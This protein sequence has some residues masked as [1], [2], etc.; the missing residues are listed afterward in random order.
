MWFYFCTYNTVAV[1]ILLNT[2]MMLN[3]D[4]LS[5]DCAISLVGKVKVKLSH[6]AMQAPRGRGNIALTH[7]CPQH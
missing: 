1:I 2:E 7:S 5:T 6:Y 4:N 3:N